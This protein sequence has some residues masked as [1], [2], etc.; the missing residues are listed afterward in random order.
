MWCLENNSCCWELKGG[1]ANF[2]WWCCAILKRDVENPAKDISFKASKNNHT[3]EKEMVLQ[4]SPPNT[5]WR[6]IFVN[7]NVC[8]TNIKQY[9]SPY[10]TNFCNH[11]IPLCAA[12]VLKMTPGVMYDQ[13]FI[14]DVVFCQEG[15]HKS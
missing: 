6:R 3:G 10:S 5:R 14:T 2:K 7:K 4:Q 9:L 12:D 15:P 1:A 13:K 8:D 11:N